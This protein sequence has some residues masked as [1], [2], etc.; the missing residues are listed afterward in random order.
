VR[1]DIFD[2]KVLQIFNE[3]FNMVTV[4]FIFCMIK[5]G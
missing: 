5:H 2:K 4:T 1:E 3:V